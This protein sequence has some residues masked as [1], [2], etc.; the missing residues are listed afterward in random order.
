VTALAQSRE[1]YAEA[2][3]VIV[4]PRRG[5]QTSVDGNLR[6]DGEPA[7]TIRLEFGRCGFDSI[8]EYPWR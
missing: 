2:N 5:N 3:F 7:Y 4:P 6:G 1:R 8:I